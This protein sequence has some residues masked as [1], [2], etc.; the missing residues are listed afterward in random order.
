[1]EV[2][3]Y[4]RWV[5]DSGDRLGRAAVAAG[6]GAPVPTCADWKVRDLLS[7]VGGVHRW[8]TVY[9]RTGRAGPTTDDEDAEFFVQVPDDE[10][11]DWYREGHARLVEALS[12]AEPAMTSWTFLTAPSPLAFWARRQ[13]HETSIHCV[14]AEASAGMASEFPVD[15]AID[16]I[17]ELLNGFFA[18]PGGRLVA[19]S[20]M[21]LGVRPIDDK[22]GW[23]VHIRPDGRTV[24]PGISDADCVI[25]GPARDLYLVLW[26]RG[27]AGTAVTVDGDTR[28][29]D[30]WRAHAVISWG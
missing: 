25:T 24:S 19:E 14:D 13:A 3:R 9:V 16:G 27:D 30:H 7:H 26:N 18:R 23:T 8:A 12:A 29:L 4:V 5:K 22:A 10:V 11:V 17:D 20:P 6:I 15:F 2:E 28:I 21:A 1:V